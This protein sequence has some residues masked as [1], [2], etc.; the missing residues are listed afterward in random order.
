MSFFF[1]TRDEVV[2]GIRDALDQEDLERATKLC[3]KA[4]KKWKTDHEVWLLAGYTAQDQEAHDE[5]LRAFDEAVQLRPDNV[6]ALAARASALLDL[7]RVDDAL[8]DAREAKELAPKDPLARH[9]L[10]TALELAGQKKLAEREYLAAER[11]DPEGY[12][13]P[14]RVSRKEFDRLVKKAIARLPAHVHEALENIHIGVKDFPGPEDQVEGE[15]PLSLQL[16]GVFQGASLRERSTEDPWSIAVPG[17]ITLFQRNLER[18]CASREELIEQIT[19]TVFHEVGH[20]L[21]MD[22]G[23][24]HGRG[25]G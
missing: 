11:L 4:I 15:R 20:Y 25:L 16:L 23:E 7:G 9:T 21:G 6:E 8:E 1:A 5:A 2:A 10:A 18:M 12:P 19:I 24:I 14:E 13:R 3:R 17:V 22:E